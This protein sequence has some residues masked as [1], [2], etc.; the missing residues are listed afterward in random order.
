LNLE[1]SFYIQYSNTKTMKVLKIS[2]T[3]SVGILAIVTTAI[4]FW[5]YNYL[6][7]INLFNSSTKIYVEYDNIDGLSPSSLVKVNGFNIG[8][9]GDIY[10]KE[11]NSG[12]IIVVLDVS[13]PL[14]IKKNGAV[15]RIESTSI[16]GG[17][18][19]VLDFP[20][21]TC[22]GEDCLVSGDTIKGVTVSL[23]GSMTSD[24]DPYLK[25]AEST[26]EAVDS[27]LRTWGSAEG[28]SDGIGKALYDIQ[29]ILANLNATSKSLKILMGGATGRVDGVLGNLE[30]VS[31]NLTESNAD[32]QQTLRNTATIT[33]TLSKTDINGT[34]NNASAAITELQQTIKTVD[35]AVKE[36]NTV[37][38]QANSGDG[39]LGKLLADDGLYNDL[40]KTL[41]NLDL[42]LE[43]LRQNPARYTRVLSK[44]R[45]PYQAP[46][47]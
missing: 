15:A 25:K 12:K 13:E 27:M 34:V 41:Q 45:P 33:Q 9:V 44:K 11:D 5:G 19:V 17:K 35:V 42:L 28:S 4:F 46:S 31:K 32:I 18:M 38:T 24:L 29:E 21:G 1:L 10:L 14:K 22:E 39:T 37:L 20:K 43:D 40:D 36:L 8:I 30:S 23:I 47:N 2:K 6:R 3:M 16:M 26:F 7:G